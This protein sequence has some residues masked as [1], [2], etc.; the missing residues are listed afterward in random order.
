MWHTDCIWLCYWNLLKATEIAHGAADWQFKS[1]RIQLSCWLQY[2]TGLQ[3][4]VRY[5]ARYL[6]I[7][8]HIMIHYYNLLHAITRYHRT[9]SYSVECLAIQWYL[10]IPVPLYHVSSV[11]E[12]ALNYLWIFLNALVCSCMFR[13]KVSARCALTAAQRSLRRR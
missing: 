9:M 12:N 10:Y 11:N 2:H 3:C 7:S 1:K 13:R 8:W 5:Y 4:I 6:K